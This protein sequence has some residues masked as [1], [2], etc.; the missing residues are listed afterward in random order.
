MDPSRSRAYLN[1]VGFANICGDT[2]VGAIFRE[3]ILQ[4]LSD[5][6]VDYEGDVFWDAEEHLESP[7][8]GSQYLVVTPENLHID[9]AELLRRIWVDNSSKFYTKDVVGGDYYDK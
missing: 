6:I 1:P 7:G 8:Y 2:R 4:S 9:E 3:R 5:I